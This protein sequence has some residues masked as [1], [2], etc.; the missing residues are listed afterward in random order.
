MN[1]TVQAT[2]TVNPALVDQAA[3]IINVSTSGVV[4]DLTPETALV[5]AGQNLV[6]AAQVTNT[7][8][9]GWSDFHFSLFQVTDPI[10]NVF[11]D[12]TSPNEPTSS[13]HRSKPDTFLII[14]PPAVTIPPSEDT[15][16]ISSTAS[17]NG[18]QP[19]RRVPDRPTARAP[20]AAA[21]GGPEF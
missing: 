20:P 7:G 5:N 8:T 16:V 3:G 11:F 21:P 15:Y 6:L 4:V 10:D 17:R 13:R 18:P 14:G 9:Q 19:N 12:V 2:S 1:Y